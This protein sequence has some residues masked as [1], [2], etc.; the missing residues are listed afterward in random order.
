MRIVKLLRVLIQ[1]LS[2]CYDNGSVH[3][4]ETMGKVPNLTI[5][6]WQSTVITNLY[7]III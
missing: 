5:V 1:N 3:A 6:N 7:G 4:V 2:V